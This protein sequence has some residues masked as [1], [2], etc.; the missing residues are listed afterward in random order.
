MLNLEEI[1]KELE[2]INNSAQ[3]EN[4]FQ[5][6]L[7]KKGILNEE[8]KKITNLSGQEKK[9]FWSKLT[10]IKEDLTNSYEKKQRELNIWN[11]NQKLNEDIVDISLEGKPINQ[12]NF[13]II[14]KV[15]RTIEEV[16]KSM[17][18][19][20]DYWHEIVKKYENFQSVN[21]PLTHP[22]T[23]AHDTFYLNDK[24]ALWDNL[25]LRTHNSAHQVQD[26]LKYWVPLKLWSPWRV[27]RV[28]NMDSWHDVMFQ[29][30]EWLIVDKN[31]S[32]AQFK[33]TMKKILSGVLW[34]DDIKIRLRPCYFPFVEPWFEIDAA[35]PICDGK[36]CPLCKQSW[37]IELLGA[38]M[39]HPNVLKNAWLD[40]N[41]RSWF[42]R[43]IGVSRLTAVKY[44]IKDIRF[45]TNWDLRF[46]KSF[47]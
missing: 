5:K 19:T 35:C 8:F 22:A 13:S 31:V 34:K 27:Y 38:W 30:A 10:S 42:A 3:L 18:F 37:W 23:E 6:Y 26:I 43:W 4:F 45:F 25:I 28:E 7:G 47:A 24:D 11:I 16:Y 39:V 9:D 40:P 36:W 21:I 29:Y 44:G 15:R 14:A 12:W 46:T 17:W 41:E 2:F 33:D 32:I 1:S 20:I